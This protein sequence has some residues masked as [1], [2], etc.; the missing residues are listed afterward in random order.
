MPFRFKAS[1]E[2]VE[3]G[4]RRIACHEMDEALALVRAGALPPERIVHQMRRA[5]KAVR[6]LLRLVR[7]V[8]PAFET[9]N[10]AFRDIAGSLS[11]LRDSKVLVDTLDGLASGPD[12]ASAAPTIAALRR[13]F[14]AVGSGQ[15]V[16]AR[17]LDHCAEQLLAARVRAASW[18]LSALGWEAIGPGLTR[19]YRA[20][21]RGMS[22][23]AQSGEPHLSHEWRKQVKY[24]WQ[25]MRLLRAVAPRPAGARVRQAAR[26]GDLLGEQHD[27]DLLVERLSA[28]PPVPDAAVVD[29]LRAAAQ[30][31]SARLHAKALKLGERLFEEKPRVFA[32]QWHAHWRDWS[33]E[34]APA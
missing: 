13:H 2:T 15:A 23:L 17:A 14:G 4:F 19:S 10:A 27:L 22:A 28:G 16:M 26:L 11:G 30:K 18:S 34:K 8:F 1:D 24:H 9:E 6:G 25:H 3:A 31:R 5:C 29:R 7:P 33:R 12:M 20:A 32:D 21:R